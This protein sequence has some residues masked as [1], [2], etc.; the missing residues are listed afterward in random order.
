MSNVLLCCATYKSTK[1]PC[2]SK[3]KHV[4]DD[5]KC[6]CGVHKHL[7]VYSQSQSHQSYSSLSPS[8]LSNSSHHIDQ[9]AKSLLIHAVK[10]LASVYQKFRYFLLV[11][12][13]IY[14]T[15]YYLKSY[16]YHQCES[17]LLKAWLYK[18]SPVCIQI[19]YV[20]D[21]CESWSFNGIQSVVKYGML[22]AGGM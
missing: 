2:T 14:V 6:Y 9:R 13:I 21:T 5:G 8:S 17:N 16:Y 4:S 3:W 22:I 20:L 1:T 11:V 7:G 12:G 15:H 10:T 19:S 18:S